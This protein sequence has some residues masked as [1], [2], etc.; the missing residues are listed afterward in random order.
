VAQ[1]NNNPMRS[2]GP[3]L[4]PKGFPDSVEDLHVKFAKLTTNMVA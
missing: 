1:N 4:S 2:L 3:A